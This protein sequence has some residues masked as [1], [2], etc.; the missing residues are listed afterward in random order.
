MCVFPADFLRTHFRTSSKSPQ[1]SI[2]STFL[3][4]NQ[5][6]ILNYIACRKCRFVGLKPTKP[7]LYAYYLLFFKEYAENSNYLQDYSFTFVCATI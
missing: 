2:F 3:P 6:T 1:K 4:E 5:C 7:T